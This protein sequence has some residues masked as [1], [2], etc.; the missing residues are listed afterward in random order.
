MGYTTKFKG[1]FDLSRKLTDNEERILRTFSASR[2]N[3][4]LA[5]NYYCQWVPTADCAG[6]E[7]DRV[8]KFYS[9]V[10]WLQFIIDQFLELWGILLIG[11]ILY[12]GEDLGDVGFVEVGVDQKVVK[13]PFLTKEN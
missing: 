10:E 1:R 5:P 7:W 6:I 13:N 8:E 12:Q 3:P 2:H 4:A 9:Y 11:K